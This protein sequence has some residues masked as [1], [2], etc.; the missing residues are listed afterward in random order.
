MTYFK[1]LG[2]FPY[3]IDKTNSFIPVDLD[4]DGSVEIASYR[5][6]DQSLNILSYRG[7]PSGAAQLVS[8]WA[9][10][11]DVPAAAPSGPAWTFQTG[12]NYYR[13]RLPVPV[14]A[15]KRAPESL[16]VFAPA[17]D[18]QAQLGVLQWNGRRLETVFVSKPGELIPYLGLNPS[19]QF[20]AADIDGDGWDEL[21][22]FSAIDLYLF[23]LRWTGSAFELISSQHNTIGSWQMSS[24]DNYQVGCRREVGGADQII[25]FNAATPNVATFY[26]S[27]GALACGPI[28]R[29]GSSGSYF[30]ANLEGSGRRQLVVFG[31]NG[32]GPFQMMYLQWLWYSQSFMPTWPSNQIL[33][34]LSWLYRVNFT[35]S[36]PNYLFKFDAS[37]SSIAIYSVPNFT[38]LELKWSVTG[39]IPGNVGLNP[40]D[41]FI[42]ADLDGDGCDELLMFSPDDHWL[43]TLKWDGAKLTAITAAQSYL[44]PTP[45][46]LSGVHLVNQ[47]QG[48]TL[49][50]LL[51][52]YGYAGGGG[53]AACGPDD[54]G[55]YGNS[56]ISPRW[57]ITSVGFRRV[58]LQES[59]YKCYV[60]WR[61]SHLSTDDGNGNYFTSPGQA[62]R[63]TVADLGG[64]N[65]SFIGGSVAAVYSDPYIVNGAGD[66]YSVQNTGWSG[67]ASTFQFAGNALALLVTCYSAVGGN[68]R[69]VDLS[70][71][72]KLFGLACCNLAGAHLEG[73]S[74]AHLA[75]KSLGA[76]DFTGAF[77]TGANLGGINVTG[78][79]WTQATLSSTDLSVIDPN[80]QNSDFSSAIMQG[81]TLSTP[82]SLTNYTGS[83]FVEA[84]LDGAHLEGA[85]LRR[86]DFTGATLRGAH[87]DGADLTG[88][89]LTGTDLGQATIAGAI[90][91][92]ATFHGTKLAGID[93]TTAAKIDRPAKFSHD[94]NNPVVLENCTIPF[95]VLGLDWSYLLMSGA[96]INDIPDRLDGLNANYAVFPDQLDLTSRSIR[97]ATF[98]HARMPDVQFGPRG[99]GPYRGTDLE[100]AVMTNASMPGGRLQQANLQG[101][102]LTNANLE[103]SLDRLTAGKPSGAVLEGA[104]LIN[105]TLDY[106]R[107]NGASFEKALFMTYPPLGGTRATAY[108]AQMNNAKLG[109]AMLYAADFSNAQLAGADISGKATLVWDPLE[110]TCRHASLSIL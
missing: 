67:S 6:A 63:M 52:E 37:T 91:T 46:V 65:L 53:N 23:T 85:I 18:G 84:N 89:I 60:N 92:D 44:G 25:A 100:N 88:A 47:Q 33:G 30:A 31:N 26:L 110:S 40:N 71:G 12:D 57:N 24:S 87:L 68:L 2:S 95:A 34:N 35:G 104:F 41:R 97:N 99:S 4:G 75:S 66:Y 50:A 98:I 62:L 105:A 61:G 108:H 72:G 42:V 5:R 21:I 69:G 101:A 15:G 56:F 74:F 81:T 80:A 3:A 107:A 96:T 90:L 59:H 20:F 82:S 19:D 70:A 48:D 58:I 29:G 13:F 17:P 45:A 11:Q 7:G 39:S 28:F 106:L 109:S 55:Q 10:A 32:A 79:I 102:D 77:L 93:L 54:G 49:V 64:G 1:D 9:C 103:A 14:A 86:C 43:F 8:A 78:A 76:T 22:I 38:S 83:K 51:Y 16:I 27:G 36:P 94:P 73:A